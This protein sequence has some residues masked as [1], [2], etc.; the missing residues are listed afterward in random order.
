MARR[1]IRT[2]APGFASPWKK[3]AGGLGAN[4]LNREHNLAR[5]LLSALVL[6]GPMG[7]G[8]AQDHAA[9]N[10]P[11]HETDPVTWSTGQYG[12]QIN[13]GVTQ[14]S[15]G[16]FW[17][18]SLTSDLTN[19]S[20]DILSQFDGSGHGDIGWV[21]LSAGANL[22]VSTQNT[23][24]SSITIGSGTTFFA[25]T[26]SISALT[27]WHRLGVTISGT[28]ARIFL[29]GKFQ[30]SGTITGTGMA[31]QAGPISVFTDGSPSAGLGFTWPW[32]SAD[33]F[34][35]NRTLSDQEIA[36]H[37]AKPYDMIVP[38]ATVRSI[39]NIPNVTPSF[40][41]RETRA[42][43][44]R[45]VR[46]AAGPVVPLLPIQTIETVTLDKWFQPLTQ[47]LRKVVRPITPA[48]AAPVLTPE[49]VSLD[50]WYQPLPQ[51][52]RAKVRT[53]SPA[54]VGG[55]I[56]SLADITLDR[57]VPALSQPLR[58]RAPSILPA[59]AA[60]VLPPL[61]PQTVTVDEWFQPLPQ[62]TRRTR[63]V[64]G[65]AIARA[66]TV[67]AAPPVTRMDW[68]QP[69][70]QPA[71]RRSIPQAAFVALARSNAPVV[72]SRRSIVHWID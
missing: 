59:A 2:R 44:P 62:P 24:G 30:Q 54:G 33:A 35:W 18:A 16:L 55:P 17:D 37:F 41:L 29:D 36:Q 8:A 45:V 68:F 51:P 22:C 7:L 31:G 50:K 3:P 48:V 69:L 38:K 21:C 6:D 47:P 53:I 27:G 15:N 60:P 4:V 28:T 52:V 40:S 64:P 65:D 70:S 10:R 57:W 14:S 20:F 32:N 46:P 63:A 72:S 71:R 9:P 58:T 19:W 49:N 61:A 66:P 23:A 34:F 12:A 67:I 5:N 42:I 11:I 25:S 1:G 43:L 56:L 13:T 26:F 39:V